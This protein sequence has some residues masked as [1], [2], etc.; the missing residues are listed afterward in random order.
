MKE[1]SLNILDI[2]QNS[3][4]ANASLV[5]ILINENEN[6][7]RFEI[8][9]D[10]CGMSQ[11]FLESVTNPFTTTRKTRCVGLG[12]PFLKMQ[13]EMSGGT[14][15]I[16]SKSEKEYID[17][18]TRVSASFSKKSIDYIPLGNIIETVCI[19]IHGAENI[20][21]LF[22]HET[23]NKEIR[24]DTREMRD[25]LGNDIPLSS[26]EIISWVREYL[27]DCYSTQ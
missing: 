13:A 17:H 6:M 9:D 3:I 4:K 10:G 19:L 24:L 12:I 23:D 11:E 26:P 22:V 20:D 5:Q 1:L 27:N 7:L 18:G 8:I 16:A 14:F 21:F 25:M 2:A 15:E